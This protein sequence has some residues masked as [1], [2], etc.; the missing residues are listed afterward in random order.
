MSGSTYT[1]LTLEQCIECARMYA[2]IGKG[3]PAQEVVERIAEHRLNGLH[4]LADVMQ[5][6]LNKRDCEE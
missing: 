4:A 6:L 1:V 5:Y 3:V 2:P